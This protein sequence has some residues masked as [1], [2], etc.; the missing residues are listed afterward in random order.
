MLGG[1]I[2]L[3][4]G[5]DIVLTERG[6]AMTIGGV[7]ALSGGV[8]AVGIGLALKRLKQIL[9]V[10]E[11][12]AAKP[13]RSAG[14]DRPVVSMVADEARAEVASAPAE[15]AE[16]ANP[17]RPPLAPTPPVAGGPLLPGLATAG[18]AG[19]AAIGAASVFGRGRSEE[20]APP[21]TPEPASTRPLPAWAPEPVRAEP[22]SE[23]ASP[24]T[25]LDLPQDLEEELSRALAETT[26]P[27]GVGT[28]PSEP[29]AT[30]R[31]FE[32][33][34]SELLGRTS[35][36]L[37]EPAPRQDLADLLGAPG[38][39]DEKVPAQEP[40]GQPSSDEAADAAP[41][42]TD[43][44]ATDAD[45]DV[46]AEAW[47]DEPQ[48]PEQ[49]PGLELEAPPTAH[50]DDD[51]FVEA[52]E[53]SEGANRVLDE[54]FAQAAEELS[55]EPFEAAAPATPVLGTYTIGGRTYRMFGDGSVE[56]VSEKGEV[57]R[58]SSMDAL[59]RH[60]AGA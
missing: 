48:E 26:I 21:P 27:S 46:P 44:K 32:E 33:G 40:D 45:L 51:L 13:V 10:L 56:A 19:A 20:S 11:A 8:I 59:R 39:A 49:E 52:Q 30:G 3:L 24:A 53:A 9:V 23:H 16:P 34:L 38:P 37:A 14:A 22:A 50:F 55:S 17:P 7:V 47:R 31:S 36:P 5:F 25:Q 12:R 43:V 1:A 60:L 2:S 15:P 42:G 54:E 35:P 28:S 41:M 6:A 58:F 4:L 57:E 18:I 29:A